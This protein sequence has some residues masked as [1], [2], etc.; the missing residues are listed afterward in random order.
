[1]AIGFLMTG[2]TAEQLSNG[3]PKVVGSHSVG[4]AEGGPGL[5]LV[6]WSTT[7]GD[8][9]VAH[10]IGLHALQALPLLAFALSRAANRVRCRQVTD[11][12]DR[13]DD[14][15]GAAEAK[16]ADQ[17][18]GADDECSVS[19]PCHRSKARRFAQARERKEKRIERA[20]QDDQRRGDRAEQD[21]CTTHE[22]PDLIRVV[23]RLTM[24]CPDRGIHT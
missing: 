11:Q 7:G 1:M 15:P 10:F 12:H 9:R 18:P 14:Q 6:N 8:L 20:A 2:P 19:G 16:R 21:I 4:V 5:P 24:P 23:T 22:S 13:Y 3:P 17:Q